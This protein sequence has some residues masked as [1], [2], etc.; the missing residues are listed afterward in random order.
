M[1][2]WARGFA[3]AVVLLCAVKLLASSELAMAQ[4]AQLA[5]SQQPHSSA[6]QDRRREINENIV[7]IIASGTSS[8]YTI[9]AEDIQNVL[10][11][12]DNPSALRVL[13]ILGRGGGG[14]V[15]DVL[16]LKGVDMGIMNPDDVEILQKQEPKVLQNAE[17]RLAYITKIANGE[18]QVLAQNRFKTLKDLEGQ[19]VNCF[20]KTSSTS[21]ACTRIFSTLNIKAEIVNFDQAEA[22]ELLKAKEIAAIVRFGG[23]PHNAFIGFTA[24]DELHFLPIDPATVPADGFQQLLT[25]YSPAILKHDYYPELIPADEPVPTITGATLLVTYNWPPD[26]ERYQHISD[27]INA[28][29]SNIEKF[30]GPGRHPKWKEINIA[31][32]VPGWTRF[33]PAQDWL[34]KWKMTE[35]QAPAET[36]TAFDVFLK[37]HGGKGVT[38][39]QREALFAEFMHWWNAQNEKKTSQR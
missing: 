30:N 18:L 3:K 29:F 13:P 22:N 4:Q 10:D 7:T 19:K 36:R 37:S 31:A 35:K 1:E 24:S 17:N 8:P 38:T 14:N 15:L 6:Y 26:T 16:L 25:H 12:P 20:K 34:D 2:S 9:F 23:A 32:D 21:L 5:T 28:F 11:Q 33:K 39:A 27:F